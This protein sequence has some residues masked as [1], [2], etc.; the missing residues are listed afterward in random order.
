MRQWWSGSRNTNFR[1]LN[2]SCFRNILGNLSLKRIRRNVFS[3]KGKPAVLLSSAYGGKTK[4]VLVR[5]A[6]PGRVHFLRQTIELCFFFFSHVYTTTAYAFDLN[7]TYATGHKTNFG[8]DAHRFAC[9]TSERL[10]REKFQI[11]TANANGISLGNAFER[12]LTRSI[13]TR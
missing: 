8:A 7:K 9:A 13:F 4:G 3:F 11:P 6:D 10:Q 5:N 2:Q 1:S 12:E